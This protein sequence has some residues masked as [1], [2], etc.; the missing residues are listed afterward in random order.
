MGRF[1]F[2]KSEQETQNQ[3]R[4]EIGRE[5]PMKN[6]MKMFALIRNWKRERTAAAT[7]DPASICRGLG[8]ALFLAGLHNGLCA[9]AQRFANRAV[10]TVPV[11]HLYAA[12][13]NGRE[14][15]VVRIF[16]AVPSPDAYV[17]WTNASPEE[18]CGT[19]T[20][21]ERKYGSQVAAIS[22]VAPGCPKMGRADLPAI[23][24]ASI[25]TSAT[26][27]KTVRLKFNV[28]CNDDGTLPTVSPTDIQQ[29]VDRLNSDY[30][31]S[32]I[33]FVYQTRF[34]N[35]TRFRNLDPA[36]EELMK[37]LYADR[38]DWQ[39]NIYV[40]DLSA[41]AP[42]GFVLLGMSTFPWDPDSLTAAGGTLMNWQAI[43]AAHNVLTH[44]IGH[45]FG[46]WHTHH[47]VTEVMTTSGAC[48]VC[49]EAVDGSNGD[50]TGDFCSDT[51]PT[52]INFHCQPPTGIDGCTGLGWGPTQPQ[53]FMGYAPDTCRTLFTP[54]QKG[55]MHA[56]IEERLLGWTDVQPV[57]EIKRVGSNVILSWPSWAS[58]YVLQ[59]CADPAGK[60][61]WTVVS[62][63]VLQ[64][65]DNFQVTLPVAE[66]GK[67]FILAGPL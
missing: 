53:N 41:W 8:A 48:T 3:K 65:V 36:D 14:Q 19:H 56:W 6:R 28:F 1:A 31:S 54:Q 29:Q 23:R 40:V 43:G 59:S 18:W 51:P 16:T 50:E 47:G 55:R 26:R 32:R 27:F 7:L 38:P 44:E 25:P 64:V 46:L 13:G 12:T 10:E 35:S 5:E 34:I 66:A 37:S 24:D 2:G 30:A 62:Q 45:S 61:G 17:A 57:L 60:K 21:F 22:A 11:M 67:F 39:V 9:T 33:R 20:C 42:P 58:Q 49:Y 63:Q 15:E 52:P 4:P